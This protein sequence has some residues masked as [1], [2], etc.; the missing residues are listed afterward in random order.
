V[1][2]ALWAQLLCCGGADS[3][4]AAGDNDYFVFEPTHLKNSISS[5]YYSVL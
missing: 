4:V 5:P 3:A 1:A 2:E